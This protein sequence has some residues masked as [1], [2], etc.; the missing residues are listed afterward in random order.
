MKVFT[1]REQ[2]ILEELV[3]IY[4]DAT[5]SEMSKISHSK[6][7]PWDVTYHSENGRNAIIDYELALDDELE[8]E[9]EEAK[10]LIREHFE[11]V[12]N[13]ELSPA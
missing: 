3:Y 2:Q 1:P 9:L 10:E 12:K 13:F 7:G 5:A 4:K 8:V 6:E 11:A